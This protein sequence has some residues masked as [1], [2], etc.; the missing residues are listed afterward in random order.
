[1]DSPL[2]GTGDEERELGEDAS[3][4][5]PS[6]RQDR[7]PFGELRFPVRRKS[8]AAVSNRA[9]RAD[10]E[11]YWGWYGALRRKLAE[12]R[13]RIRGDGSM[14]GDIVQPARR[15]T[16]LLEHGERQHEIEWGFDGALRR[17]VMTLASPP[18]PTDSM[19]SGGERRRIVGRERLR[20][21][22]VRLL[23]PTPDEGVDETVITA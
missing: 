19:F 18:W 13:W 9:T 17:Y 5:L 21:S 2:A 20:Q 4:W 16:L 10:R 23:V 12:R 15:A 6:S 8:I 3:T 1:M 22:F 7:Q 11:H 14:A